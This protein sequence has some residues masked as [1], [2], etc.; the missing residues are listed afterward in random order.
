MFWRKRPKKKTRSPHKSDRAKSGAEDC[1]CSKKSVCAHCHNAPAAQTQE[2][3][4]EPGILRKAWSACISFPRKALHFAIESIVAI[5][6]AMT[7][8]P[9]LSSYAKELAVR[10]DGDGVKLPG[11]IA[12]VEWGKVVNVAVLTDIL[13]RSRLGAASINT[14]QP[15]S[16]T[17]LPSQHKAADTKSPPPGVSSVAQSSQGAF[18]RVK[19]PFS[20]NARSPT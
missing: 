11:F 9:P 5:S 2:D 10:K 18:D 16:P 20:R 19:N 8:F 7:L 4:K 15:A 1:G 14:P 3:S 6:L 12:D 13:M 17:T